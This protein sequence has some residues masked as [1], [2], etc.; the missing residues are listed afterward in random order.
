MPSEGNAVATANLRIRRAPKRDADALGTLASGAAVPLAGAITDGWAPVG[1]PVPG[2]CF[3]GFLRAAAVRFDGLFGKITGGKGRVSQ[4]FG[5]IPG[6]AIGGMYDYVTS[7]GLDPGMHGGIDVGLPEGTP[8]FAPMAGRVVCEGTGKGSEGCAAF[9]DDEGGAG[10]IELALDNGDRLVLGHCRTSA[11]RTG[12]RVEAGT[13]VGT[14]GTAGTGGHV[15]VELRMRSADTAIGQVLVDPALRL[16]AGVTPAPVPSP[17]PVPQPEPPK[18]E[19][20]KSWAGTLTV[21]ED[22]R[23]TFVPEAARKDGP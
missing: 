16:D 5:N 14:S 23:A 10:R 12:A 22:G 21:E 8:L 9:A 11:V 1:G 7:Y 15:H 13:K 6:G 19:W 17:P 20:P 4:P 3:A 18:G 2:F